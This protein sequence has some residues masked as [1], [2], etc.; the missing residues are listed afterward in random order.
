MAEQVAGV[1]GGVSLI[2]RADGR[3]RFDLARRWTCVSRDGRHARQAMPGR[4][5]QC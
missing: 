5:R 2:E 4:K 3:Q 1:N